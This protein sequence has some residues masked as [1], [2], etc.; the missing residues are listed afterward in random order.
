MALRK[1]AIKEVINADAEIMWY[2]LNEEGQT[3]GLGGLARAAGVNDNVLYDAGSTWI[4]TA[5]D[6][7]PNMSGGA[8][9]FAIRRAINKRFGLT[10]KQ[11]GLIQRVNDQEPDQVKRRANIVRAVERM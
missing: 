2:Y 6:V 5:N 10:V 4:D 3:C 8:S 7:L 9:I 11:M 1:T